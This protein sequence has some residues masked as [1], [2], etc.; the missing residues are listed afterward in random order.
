M[1]R[2][3]E[4]EIRLGD[5]GI[6]LPEPPEA[7]GAY[8]PVR[9]VSSGLATVT[10]YVAGQIPVR[11]GRVIHTGRVHGRNIEEARESARLCAINVLAQLRR[12]MRVRG[13]DLD[14]IRQFVMLSGFV[15]SGPA[16]GAHPK[17]IDAASELIFDLFGERGRHSRVA[18]GASS[19]PLNSMTEIGAVAEFSVP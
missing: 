12:E 14:N 19:L 8:V 10:A 18:V 15:N 9:C 1:W 6:I 7:A 11:D 17:V 16:F 2:V 3:S 5:L 4:V 13:V